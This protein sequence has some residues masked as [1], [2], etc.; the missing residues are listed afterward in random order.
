M[1]NH[2]AAL[3]S[4]NPAAVIF[5]SALGRRA[6]R[7]IRFFAG[8][9]NPLVL[10][11]AGTR[12]MPIAGVLHHRG[13]R[14]GRDYSTPVGMRRA[15]DVF[16]VPLTFGEMSHWYRNVKAAASATVRYGGRVELVDSPQVVEWADAV[17]AFPRYE[18]VLFRA[19]GITY[20]LRL[21][22][23]AGAR[24]TESGPPAR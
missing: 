3:D 13:W 9:F 7:A 22:V 2:R 8:I 15:G 23:Q 12:M 1:L 4:T 21:T 5:P 10:A 11:I 6:R 14:T 16:F 17:Q 18:R 20:F 19:I 24:A